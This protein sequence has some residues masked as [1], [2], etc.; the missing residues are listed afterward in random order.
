[1]RIMFLLLFGL[2]ASPLTWGMSNQL[3][4][5]LSPYL[6]LHSQDPVEWQEWNAKTIELARKQN[7]LLFVSIGYFSCHWCHVMQKESYRNPQIAALLNENFIP[8]KVDRELMSSL[9]AEMQDFSARTN[10]RSG[11]PLNVFITPEGYPLYALL[12]APPQDFYQ[13]IARLQSRWKEE[14]SQLKLIA[15]QV[16]DSG[17]ELNKLRATKFSKAIAV[18]YREKL[19]EEALARGDTFNG[20]FGSVNKFPM[21]PQLAALLEAYDQA[22]QPKLRMLL[23]LTLDK[24]A[25]QGL[26]D[27][28]GGG[29]FR[30]TTDPDWRVP[31][32]EKM[33]YDN[34]QLALLY[35]RAADVLKMP[36]YRTT[37]F[38]ALDFILDELHN[39][40]SAGFMTSTSAID[41]QGREGGVYLWDKETLKNLLS[42]GEYELL[43]KTWGMATPSV[44]EWGYLPITITE[45]SK[46][47]SETLKRIYTKL[48]KSRRGRIILKDDKRLAALNGLALMAF[49]EA[50]KVAPIYKPAAR[51]VAQFLTEEMWHSQKLYKA[52]SKG[53]FTG[54]GE[55]EDYVFVAAGLL[56]YAKLTGEQNDFAV[57]KNVANQAWKMFYTEKGWRQQ[58]N[59][60]LA[61]QLTEKVIGDSSVPSPSS[62]LIKVSLQ[63]N[64]KQL[65]K[66]AL[67]ALQSGFEEMDQDV[68]SYATHITAL[69]TH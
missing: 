31:H 37:A 33:L 61:K 40:E 48:K 62:E 68:F 32:F 52:K 65:H 67:E 42:T 45:P 3:K 35:L 14:S 24:M 9:D 13:V 30:Y 53:R 28:I 5:N 63:M 36:K 11:W 66:E 64:D 69:N 39:V 26:R 1:M 38:E 46:E 56:R 7:K 15:K 50:A 47:E 10:G 22:P 20:G 25:S 21:T 19:I 17:G 49:S 12:Y 54:E 43:S 23:N 57:A 2:I 51:E 60:L 59:S 41:A 58:T 4:D 29:F 55:L 16:A 8:V 6:A 44:F 34:A 27:H 18:R